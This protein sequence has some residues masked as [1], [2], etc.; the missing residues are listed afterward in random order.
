[1]TPLDDAP[2]VSICIP[3]YQAAPWIRQA[4][5]SA[6][7]QDY[8]LVEIVVADDASTD[9]TADLASSIDDDRIRVLTSDRRLGMAANWNRSVNAGR[10]E[11]IKLLMQDD[12]LEPHCVSRMAS[13]LTANP[14]VGFVFAA[15]KVALDE[16]EHEVGQSLAT[17]GNLHRELE[18]LVEVN[19]GRRI[20]EIMQRERFRTNH[21]GEP[22]VVMVRRA[23]FK[24]VGLF[25]SQLRQWIDLEMW[26][27]LAAFHDVGFIRDSLATFHVH[28]TSA[29]SRNSQSGAAWLDR[30]WLVEG[31]RQH[32]E[33]RKVVGH[34][35][36]VRAWGGAI[37]A[38]RTRMVGHA[39]AGDWHEMRRL[40]RG[41]LA[42]VGWLMSKP[43]IRLHVALPQ[44]GP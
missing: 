6:L 32:P 8:P 26:L 3:T 44:N 42:Y 27:R 16:S 11:Y 40:A 15:R 33:L 37:K 30:V 38:E 41:T 12:T 28:G 22:T 14:S 19:D 23:A 43:R 7:A 21:V 13:V 10:G 20:F 35:A 36:R 18:P 39:S 24:R 5:A 9:G 25:N 4:I 2:L 1:M 34:G 29:T 31:L 17:L